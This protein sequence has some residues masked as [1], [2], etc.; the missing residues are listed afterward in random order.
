MGAC[1]GRVFGVVRLPHQVAQF[2]GKGFFAA[3]IGLAVYFVEV[4]SVRHHCVA[5]P[6]IRLVE[7]GLPP[8]QQPGDAAAAAFRGF[9]AAQQHHQVAVMLFPGVAQGLQRGVDGHRAGPGFVACQLRQRIGVRRGVGVVHPHGVRQ[10]QSRLQ[11]A[12]GVRLVGDL[13]QIVDA[14]AGCGITAARLHQASGI[15]HHNIDGLAD[16]RRRCL[17]LSQRT[18]V[19]AGKPRGL[20]G[21]PHH[22]RRQQHV[23]A[24]RRRRIF[25]LPGRS[26]NDPPTPRVG[27][28]AHGTGARVHAAEHRV[29]AE[30]DHGIGAVRPG[31]DVRP[32]AV[33][34]FHM[35]AVGDDDRRPTRDRDR[36]PIARE[37]LQRLGLAEHDRLPMMDPGSMR[38]AGC[39]E[40]GN[41]T[42]VRLATFRCG[43]HRIRQRGN[44][45][46]L[47][48]GAH[49][50]RSAD[51]IPGGAGSQHQRE[52]G[53]NDVLQDREFRGELGRTQD[54]P[55]LHPPPDPT[56]ISENWHAGF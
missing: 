24:A 45:R 56:R 12:V 23:G 40:Y 44:A 28:Q 9:E 47:S 35:P 16:L 50:H 25:V 33:L 14:G 31:A 49:A 54:I 21:N 37:R 29:P 22:F 7:G 18:G 34:M 39:I 5:E 52:Q 17:F 20:R 6:G 10:P 41:Y 42:A 1:C 30:G 4:R 38:F 51:M 36:Q 26:G 15:A 19:P 2:V 43:G 8:A 53:N 27:G 3:E 48:E 55:A 46:L 11:A 32:V 13:D